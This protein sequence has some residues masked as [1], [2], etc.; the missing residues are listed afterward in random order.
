MPNK[1][2]IQEVYS[3]DLNEAKCSGVRYLQYRIS[4][5]GTQKLLMWLC[6]RIYE[7]LSFTMKTTPTPRLGGG[8][9]YSSSTIFVSVGN[10]ASALHK[11]PSHT[12]LL[13]VCGV[14]AVWVA[15]PHAFEVGPGCV[16]DG[17]GITVLPNAKNPA[18]GAAW[19]VDGRTRWRFELEAGDAVFIPRAWWHAVKAVS[20][21]GAV[22]IALEVS[23]SMRTPCLHV[24]VGYRNPPQGWTS[25]K[26]VEQLLA[27][28]L[29]MPSRPNRVLP[30]SLPT[31]V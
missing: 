15:D 10:T 1:E 3:S 19:E 27:S 17:S 8:V 7:R 20:E 9:D 6:P 11:D 23:T 22:A 12:L 30:P 16:D 24:H 29:A 2:E 14:R 21:G 31:V 18:L 5:N 26:K 28:C 13:C 25:A 4:S